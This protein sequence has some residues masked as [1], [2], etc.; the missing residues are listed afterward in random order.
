MAKPTVF[1][2]YPSR[3]PQIGSA[4]E[5]AVS[6]VSD[7]DL[8]DAT[9]W[10]Q[11]DVAGRFIIEPILEAI[12]N[13]ELLAA[14]ITKLNFNVT[15]EVGYAIGKGKRVLPLVNPALQPAL[16][17]IE[18]LGIFDTVGYKTYEN[19]NDLAKFISGIEDV[20]PLRAK[21][22]GIDRTAPIYV[23]DTLHKTDTSLRVIA[24][25]KR[26]RFKFR[27]FDPKEQPRLSTL[28][29]YRNVAQSI[30]I[31][32]NLLP[33][34]ATDFE[35]N[36]LRG[37]FLAGLS[38]GMEKNVLV[39]QEG[40]DPVPV[41]YRDF[42]STYKHPDDIDKYINELAPRVV[43]GLQA[44]AGQPP[45]KAAGLL[46]Q[47]DLGALAAENEMSTLADYYV[48][49]DEYNKSLSGAVRL[50][51]GRKGSGKTA[52]F[53]RVRDKVRAYRDNIVLDLKPDGHQLQRFKYMVLNLLADAV[54]EHVSMAFWEYILLLE[55]AHKLLEKDATRHT[56]DHT[57]FESYNRLAKLYSGNYGSEDVDFSGRML[58]LVQRISNDFVDNYGGEKT[59][60][61]PAN[62]VTRLI[63]KHDIP[64]LQQELVDYL[65]K[66]EEVWILFDNID[67][68]W[69]TR[70][71]EPTDILILRS[72]LEATRH[73]ERF[74]ARHEITVRTMVFVRNDV[75]ELLVDESPDRGKES[76]VSLDWTEPDR[77]RELLRR[78]LVYNAFTSNATFQEVWPQICISHVHGEESSEYLINR[79]LM[80]PRNLLNLVGHCK[81]NAV[82]ARH[83]QITQDDIVHAYRM[84]SA[85]IG[86]EI[87]LEIRDV[88]PE[89]VDILYYF[90][91]S[92]PWISLSQVKESLK[93][94]PV[95]S[96]D[97][98]RLIEI[99]LWF[100]FLGV[101]RQDGTGNVEE[102]YIYDV[103]YDMKKLLH[104]GGGLRDDG[105]ELCIH[106]A[107]WPF[108]EI[109]DEH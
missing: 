43:E 46:E 64:A 44:A 90:I 63:Y 1:F 71:V 93:S 81:S 54:K 105:L 15:F 52:L 53:F 17:E 61:L 68:A 77:L 26:A 21:D 24:K 14:D 74:F 58:E 76:K 100:S 2:A 18:Q 89:A 3:P 32:V 31:I 40:D 101:L 9:Y 87:G 47:L 23:L 109:K 86:N 42:V 22:Y 25:V 29:A 45:P 73:V 98:P 49:T 62:E 96:Q 65:G 79:C 99:L 11:L 97:W 69:P 38:F 66:K 30:A 56:R 37:A 84:F 6:I 103:F 48:P 80:R 16:R 36:N 33:S 50:A 83:P 82:N 57:I 107:F 28:E 92:A 35:S 59:R 20:Q 94:S 8:V 39:L 91:G 75:Y 70:G 12:A 34:T 104:L 4:I 55:I 7:A 19:A 67:K 51:V 41:D 88:F 78:R 60:Y 72:L 106:R 13:A 10:P 85:D 108:L 95:K 102:T 27:S 5:K